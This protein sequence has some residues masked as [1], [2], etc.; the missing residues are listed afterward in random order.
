MGGVIIGP[1]FKAI[2]GQLGTTFGGNH[3]GC[4]GAI[5]VL[6]IMEEER[7]IENAAKVG[8]FLTS[9]LKKFPGIKEIRGSGLMIG[10]EFEQP[11][12]EIR[13]KLLFEQKVFTGVA[14]LHIIRLLPP[15][16]LSMDEAKKFLVRFK[17][18]L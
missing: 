14:G 2:H 8:D 18:C 5:A 3:L 7:L 16:S 10:L 9:E 17:K 12:K 1:M 11:I 6:E 4:A 15:L 13:S